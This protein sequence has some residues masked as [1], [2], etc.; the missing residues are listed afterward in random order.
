MLGEIAQ[1]E[2]TR[3]RNRR[4]TLGNLL[5]LDRSQ[6]AIDGFLLRLQCRGSRQ[7]SADGQEGTTG[8]ATLFL[9]GR[10][11]FLQAGF[12]MERVVFAGIQTVHASHTTAIIYLMIFEID[13][14]RFAL[15]GAQATI[16]AFRAIYR[17]TEKSKTRE[18]S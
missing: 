4:S 14:S 3:R 7:R 11:R 13:A 12:K 1:A 9:G 17:W 10:S 16:F 15:T 8:F 2:G 5:L 18:E 6:T